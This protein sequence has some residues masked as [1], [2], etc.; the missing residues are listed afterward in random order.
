MAATPT[1]V[2][3]EDIIT[4]RALLQLFNPLPS[5]MAS[6]KNPITDE[7]VR[8]GQMLF[9]DTRFSLT[10][11]NSCNSCHNLQ[12]Y[13][14]DNQQFS[15]G[16]AGGKGGRNSPTVFNA[17]LH[18]AQFWDGRAADVEEQAKGPVLNPVEMAMPS[19][20]EV[21]KVIQS[22]PGYV[23]MFKE[24]FPNDPDPVSYD[25]FARAVGAFER[26]LVT[27]SRFDAFLNGDEE[28][29]TTPEKIGL[30]NFLGAGCATCHNGPALGGQLYQ[31]LGLVNPWPE[32]KDEGR[33]EVTKQEA[34]KFMFKVPGLR[35]VA[36]TY[37]YLHDGSI[38]DL[39]KLT[40]MMAEY[41]LGRK[42]DENQIDS[43][44]TFLNVLTG[45]LP[46]D[47]VVKPEL[48]A[49]GP[50]TPKPKGGNGDKAG[51]S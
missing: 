49:D 43:I 26:K 14:V 6:E 35:N 4:N 18:I 19:A 34:D 45:D 48:P 15:T 32:L 36:K 16:D 51:A 37:P 39:K 9:H 28:A 11:K 22:I 42:L 27:P 25:N 7:K 44:V 8:L 46:A 13:G 29:L 33:A 1:A 20:D 47:L 5:E 12:T 3:G 50:D 10:R 21:V 2:A 41:Q 17:A 30:N 31:K 24:V 40:S 23:T 38:T